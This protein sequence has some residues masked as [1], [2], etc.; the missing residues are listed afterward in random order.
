MFTLIGLDVSVAY[1][2]SLMA[3]VMILLMMSRD[4]RAM[5][6]GE[7]LFWFVMSLGVVVGFIIAYP[8]NVWLVA[9]GM[10]HGLMTV[11]AP[12]KTSHG[13]SHAPPE[14]HEM[15]DEGARE[16]A[17]TRVTGPQLTALTDMAAADPRRVSFL[18]A[19]TERGDR[20]LAARVV[21]GVKAFDLDASVIRWTILPGIEVT[22]YAIN[23]QVPGP[24][25]EFA[26]GD[27][28]RITFTN[29]LPEPATMH[30]HG[31]VVPNAMDGPGN[32]TQV[33]VPPGGSYVYGYVVQQPGT[34]FYHSHTRPDRQ[35]ALGLYGALLIHPRDV[36]AEPKAD[37][38][39]SRTLGAYRGRAIDSQGAELMVLTREGSRWKIRAI[40]WSSHASRSR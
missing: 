2:Y 3:P 5:W 33:P 16:D 20:T 37:Y 34:Y 36:G 28:V 10:K 29:H 24:R 39:T 32:I 27:H 1:V 18:A 7:L 31:L 14:R 15:S 4:M 9:K 13:S 11:R 19:A 30:W 17:A 38:Q 26:E 40:H 22:A 12:A 25:L 23:N 6:P 35:Q 21:N 8:V